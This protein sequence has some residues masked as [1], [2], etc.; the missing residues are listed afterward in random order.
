MHPAR[1]TFL[2]RLDGVA[3]K[4]VQHLLQP[5]PVGTE[6]AGIRGKV[7][8]KANVSGGAL[9]LQQI[10]DL[11]PATDQIHVAKGDCLLGNVFA[12]AGQ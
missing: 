12:K 10:P 7:M 2:L 6:R 5:Q 4:V 11:L 3:E 9:V 1:R 8:G